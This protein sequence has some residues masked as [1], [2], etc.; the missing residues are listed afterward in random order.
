MQP[1]TPMILSGLC[2]LACLSRPK[3]IDLVFGMLP[4]ATGVK[5][6]GVGLLR[7]IDQFVTLLAQTGHD[8]LAV[9]HVHL[10]ADSFDIELLGHKTSRRT[11]V[12]C[13]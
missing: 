8:Q 10:A 9:E 5:Q 6:N 3:R 7:A 12:L 1:S 4:H 11:R 2:F 13:S